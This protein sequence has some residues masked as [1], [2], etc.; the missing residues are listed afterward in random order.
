MLK[1]AARDNLYVLDFS[2]FKDRAIGRNQIICLSGQSRLK[3][4][5]V[6]RIAGNVP[7][8][9]R[10]WMD[11]LSHPQYSSAGQ[12]SLAARL[13]KIFDKH[14]DQFVKDVL[15]NVKPRALSSRAVQKAV[16][17]ASF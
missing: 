7:P 15:R 4:E 12:E 1:L 3:N 11:E 14:C 16:A 5:I 17:V 13:S 9:S 10:G 8:C 6:I 2:T